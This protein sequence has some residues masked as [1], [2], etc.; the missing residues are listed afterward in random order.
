[1]PVCVPGS[2][3]VFVGTVTTVAGRGSPA[4]SAEHEAL[5][6]EI[7]YLVDSPPP[8]ASPGAS[9]VGT[10]PLDREN[11]PARMLCTWAYPSSC[12]TNSARECAVLS[13]ISASLAS[14]MTRTNGSVPD[15]RMST[16]ASSPSEA[17][18]SCT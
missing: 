3:P 10:S 12:L 15:G 7:P 13:A 8:T 17:S 1:M 11:T 6:F 18:I 5:P 4:D 14:T 2:L 9:S 16:R